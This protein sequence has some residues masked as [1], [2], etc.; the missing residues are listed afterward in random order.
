[1]LFTLAP[2]TTTADIDIAADAF[3]DAV[4]ALRAMSPLAP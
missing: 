2:S 1:V 4:A 3:V